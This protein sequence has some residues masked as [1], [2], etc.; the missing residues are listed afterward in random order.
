MM[1]A[2]N[3][4]TCDWVADCDGE[5]RERVVRDGGDSGVMMKAVAAEDGDGRQRQQ[6]KTMTAADDSGMRTTKGKDR[7]R[8]QETAET[9]GGDNG[10]NSRR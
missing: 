8:Q 5:G 7:S 6:K 3:N 4:N 1:V 2:D 9:Q 10:C